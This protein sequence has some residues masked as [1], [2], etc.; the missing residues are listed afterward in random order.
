MGGIV[1]VGVDGRSCRIGTAARPLLAI[2]GTTASGKSA[3]GLEL[4]RQLDGEIVSADALQIYRGMDIGTAKPT[5]SERRTVRHHCIDIVPPAE[6]FSAGD[7][8]RAAR[9]A[10]AEIQARGRLPI[11]VG[12]SG[13]YMRALITGLDPLLPSD[14]VWRSA[15]LRVEE[16]RGPEF[17]RRMIETLDPGWAA[18]IGVRD[19]QRALRG[20]EVT[21]RTGVPFSQQLSE[22]RKAVD[23]RFAL[24]AVWVGISWARHALWERIEA[25][26]DRMLKGGWIAEVERLQSA[27]LSLDAHAL[28][29]IGYREIGA[30]LEGSLDLPEV[31]AAIVRATRRYAKRQSTWFRRQT[32]ARWFHVRSAGASS[33]C[34]VPL[35]DRQV[36]EAELVDVVINHAVSQGATISL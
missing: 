2:V 4:A 16:R 8:A 21:L 32:P 30:Y 31:R 28:Q 12:G 33:P 9:D 22:Q 24:P 7:Y 3:L 27:G 26:V 1:D 19:R 17:T 35:D 29:A 14:P 20:I 23:L 10:V 6:R 13:L 5:P 18:R 36:E 25:R 11:A 15:L 34:S